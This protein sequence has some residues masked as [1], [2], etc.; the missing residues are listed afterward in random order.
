MLTHSKCVER[1]VSAS[2]AV[3]ALAPVRLDSSDRLRWSA[4]QEP[5]VH[6]SLPIRLGKC[7]I[8][9]QRNTN[10]CVFICDAL[11]R[12]GASQPY[13]LGGCFQSVTGPNWITL[14][15]SAVPDSRLMWFL[16]LPEDQ[17]IRSNSQPFQREKEIERRRK[18]ENRMHFCVVFLAVID[19]VGVWNGTHWQMFNW[20]ANLRAHRQN[21]SFPAFLVLS[22]YFWAIQ[23]FCSLILGQKRDHFSC[24]FSCIY[25]CQYWLN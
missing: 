2:L 11:P 5:C 9:Q 23:L 7:N 17:L 21:R 20:N 12:R 3:S 19:F 8:C 4:S 14:C 15:F 16:Q 1:S 18:R 22:N 6:I 25:I 13:N 10:M 24:S